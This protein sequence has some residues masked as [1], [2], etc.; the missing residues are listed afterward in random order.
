MN[1]TL[2]AGD[3]H[4]KG[5]LLPFIS[6]MADREHADRIVLLGDICDDWHVS[7]T[8]MIRFMERFASW[9][10]AESGRR[11]IV[12]LL[13]NHDV[14]Y[15]M[16]R[17]SASFARVRAQAPGF[18]PGAQ[19]RVHELMKDI[20]MRIAWTDGTIVATHA[21]LTRRWGIRRF[22]HAWTGMTAD[23]IAARLNRLPDRPGSLAALYMDDD[24][25]LWARPGHGDYDGRLTQVS[26]HRF[27]VRVHRPFRAVGNH[28]GLFWFSIYR[29][30]VSNGAP[31]A[32]PA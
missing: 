21:G 5:D 26:G 32:V 2:F 22:G 15:F 19:R 17:G 23:R 7:N 13:G 4:A 27:G 30:S 8:G 24:G 11:E 6:N 25:P 12:P 16:R 28:A 3:L 29:F 9:Y 31:P 10:R 20:P 1:R 14:P 18:K